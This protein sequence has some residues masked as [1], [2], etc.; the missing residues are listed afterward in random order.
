MV[1]TLVI[2][3]GL[4]AW[5]ILRSLGNER[6]LRLNELHAQIEA[7]ARAAAAAQAA[8]EAHAAKAVHH[9]PTTHSPLTPYFPGQRS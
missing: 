7:E 8:A 9:D 4:S 5:A 2:G 1:L 6:Q 3:S